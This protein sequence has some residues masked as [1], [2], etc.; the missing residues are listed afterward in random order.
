MNKNVTKR[1]MKL[2]EPAPLAV[3]WVVA[4]SAASGTMKLLEFFGPLSSGEA[5]K[6][7]FFAKAHYADLLIAVAVFVA[8][9]LFMLRNRWS[10][11]ILFWLLVYLA[12]CDVWDLLHVSNHFGSLFIFHWMPYVFTAGYFIALIGAI[13]ALFSDS[14]KEYLKSGR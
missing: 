7:N 3:R 13:C 5:N 11:H 2:F 12:S 1:F 4:F 6:M 8:V 10:A 14:V 9:A